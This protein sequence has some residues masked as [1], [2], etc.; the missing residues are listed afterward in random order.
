MFSGLKFYLSLAVSSIAAIFFALFK[1]KS[2]ENDNLKE[3]VKIKEESLRI[4]EA[5]EEVSTT[6][7]QELTDT[8]DEIDKQ[9]KRLKEN[10][11]ITHTTMSP[12]S[13][14]LFNNNR[15]SS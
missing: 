3:Q 5:K 14:R 8:I 9:T 13:I 7:R 15:K 11:E 2:K 4:V 1:H 10:E 12:E 6:L